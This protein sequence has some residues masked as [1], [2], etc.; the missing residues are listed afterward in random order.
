MAKK[1]EMVDGKLQ[2]EAVL[3]LTSEQ[4]TTAKVIAGYP[5]ETKRADDNTNTPDKTHG[6][7]LSE[8]VDVS[9]IYK[10]QSDEDKYKFWLHGYKVRE[11]QPALRNQAMVALGL[12]APSTRIDRAEVERQASINALRKLYADKVISKSA[13]TQALKGYGISE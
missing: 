9:T 12:S 4:A 3:Y 7:Y 11:A 10:E 8:L 6:V 13:L 2:V 1:Q 5:V